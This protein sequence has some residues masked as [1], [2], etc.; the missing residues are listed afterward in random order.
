ML[1]VAC[2]A[3]S[4]AY[5]PRSFLCTRARMPCTVAKLLDLAP[6]YAFD[7]HLI[8]C[9]LQCPLLLWSAKATRILTC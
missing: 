6:K 9:E 7:G 2:A 3:S 4:C 5:L 8:D 1:C